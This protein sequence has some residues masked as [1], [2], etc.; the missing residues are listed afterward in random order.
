MIGHKS[1]SQNGLAFFQKGDAHTGTHP[2][3]VLLHGVGM[4]AESWQRQIDILSQM[5]QIYAPD[6][7]GH[8]DSPCLDTDHAQLA[9]YSA[10]IKTFIED[11]INTPVILMGHS[12]GAL[13]TMDIAIKYDRMCC[14]FIA[15]SPV[16]GRS[17]EAR[18]AVTTRAKNLAETSQDEDISTATLAR[19]FGETPSGDEKY[20]AD[21]CRAWLQQ[22]DR[23]GYAAAY[24]AFAE[25]R[26]P[27]DQD[28]AKL[29]APALFLTGEADPNSTPH[30]SQAL[31]KRVPK[32]QGIT[33]PE[34]RHM[35]QMTHAE[36]VTEALVNF[37]HACEPVISERPSA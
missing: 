35:L 11:E 34:A 25:H 20:M 13:I 3:V 12:L 16:Y 28:F 17:A 2:P 6:L 36:T 31:A 1:I 22:A 37:I 24:R 14:G 23:Q 32:G 4:R 29:T 5:F 30:M 19:W 26:D 15:L 33:I 9:D 8:G 7:P 27:T 21:Q 10:A 18:K